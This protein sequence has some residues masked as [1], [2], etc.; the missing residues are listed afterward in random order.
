MY[1]AARLSSYW[2][3]WAPAVFVGWTDTGASKS[4]RP[5]GSA[6]G[7]RKW[8][9]SAADAQ[10][11]DGKQPSKMRTQQAER[12]KLRSGCQSGRL[13]YRCTAWLLLPRKNQ[14]NGAIIP[15]NIVAG[16]SQNDEIYDA[17]LQLKIRSSWKWCTFHNSMRYTDLLRI[18]CTSIRK[19]CAAVG[20]VVSGR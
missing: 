11:R 10:E 5:S 2:Q 16:Y 4:S 17:R 7:Q 13:R 18:S 14:T 15:Q 6:E 1:S 20:A 12:N 9:H 19:N 8:G 3:P